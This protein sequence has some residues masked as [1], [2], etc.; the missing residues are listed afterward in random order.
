MLCER[1]SVLTKRMRVPGLTVSALGLTPDEE[2]VTVVPPV[3]GDEGELPPQ[4]AKP[5]RI[6]T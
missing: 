1:L 2:I 3:E 6:A 5:T 4:P